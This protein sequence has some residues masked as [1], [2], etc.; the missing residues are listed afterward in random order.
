MD[1]SSITDINEANVAA[2]MKFWYQGAAAILGLV[3]AAE[4]LLRALA[5]WEHRKTDAPR[6]LVA[7]DAPANFVLFAHSIL[8]DG[9]FGTAIIGSGLEFG[10]HISSWHIPFNLYTLPLYFLAAEFWHYIYHRMSHE[11][12]VLWADHSIHHSSWRLPPFTFAYK[13]LTIM[14]LAMLG[15]APIPFL[16]LS[17]L[18][19]FQTF[20]HT[21]R[22]GRLGWFDTVFCSPVNH[23]IHH[24]CN[25]RYIDKNY[26]GMTVIWDRL[27]GTFMLPGEEKIKFGITK[28]VNSNDPFKIWVFEFKYLFRDLWHAPGLRAKMT[29]LL[30]K[31]GETYSHGIKA[32][33][34]EAHDPILVA[35]E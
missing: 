11:V 1:W 22:I 34:A 23:S 4:I 14:P 21:Q 25:P 32:V 19:S 12:R 15:F 35:A 26:G 13:A 29:V 27:L 28:D 7:R 2:F 3:L 30:G 6:P 17:R 31:P 5:W 24:A 18:I 16:L 10:H 20:I 9:I 8:I 33:A